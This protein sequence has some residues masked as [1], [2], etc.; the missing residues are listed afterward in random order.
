M[1]MKVLFINGSPNEYGCTYT[2][3]ERV[4]IDGSAGDD[5]DGARFLKYQ[6]S[7]RYCVEPMKVIKEIH[8]GA[9]YSKG[10]TI[11]SGKAPQAPLQNSNFDGSFIA[12]C[13]QMHYMYSMPVNRIL[14]LM[15]R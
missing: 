10:G 11:I 7:V 12:F 4:I 6:D 13:A 2:C 3:E 14:T 9:L 1:K 5:L 15:T 8:R